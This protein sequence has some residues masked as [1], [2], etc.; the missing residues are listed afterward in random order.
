MVSLVDQPGVTAATVERLVA[1]WRPDGSRRSR[2]R[3]RTAQPG[4]VAGG[5][6]GAGRRERCRG[7]GARAWL[8]AH[9]DEVSEVACDDVGSAD[10]IDTPA[11][12]RR[13][14]TG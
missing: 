9:P 8:R 4:A 14:T 10:D 3:R 13:F 11:D 1:A 7:P 2:R 6:L 5:D 12:L